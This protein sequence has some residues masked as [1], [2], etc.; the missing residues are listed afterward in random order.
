MKLGGPA[1]GWQVLRAAAATGSAA[2]ASDPG[3]VVSG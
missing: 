1:L 2:E 3:A